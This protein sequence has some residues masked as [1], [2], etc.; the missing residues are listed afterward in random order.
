MGKKLNKIKENIS[1]VAQKKTPINIKKNV[2]I[3]FVN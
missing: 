1:R 3:F 2:A